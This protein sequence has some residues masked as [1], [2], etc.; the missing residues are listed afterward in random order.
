MEQGCVLLAEHL[1]RQGKYTRGAVPAA[2]Q[3][4]KGAKLKKHLEAKL[5]HRVYVQEGT[6]V[7]KSRLERRGE[8]TRNL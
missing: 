7:S 2:G 3:G 8:K 6:T 4:K 1:R 5:I